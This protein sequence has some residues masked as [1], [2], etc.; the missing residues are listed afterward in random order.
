M[1]GLPQEFHSDV[2]AMV[3]STAWL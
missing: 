1:A 2:K 3:D